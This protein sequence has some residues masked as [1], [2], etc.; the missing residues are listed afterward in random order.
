MTFAY[1]SALHTSKMIMLH[2]LEQG[3]TSSSVLWL[4]RRSTTPCPSFGI[5][6][7]I[8]LLCIAQ[9]RLEVFMP[10]SLPNGRQ[11]YPTTDEFG[12]MRI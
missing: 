5:S 12:G 6:G 8:C 10:Q 1:R 2:L 4:L 9:G 3:A 11:T 7:L